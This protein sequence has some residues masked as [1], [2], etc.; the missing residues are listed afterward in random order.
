MGRVGGKDSF[1]QGRKDVE[2][3]AGIMVK[4]KAV[5]RVSEA[6]GEQV[7]RNSQRER[8]LA[9]SG[10]VVSFQPVPLLYIALDGTGVPVVPR[11]TEG[12]SGKDPTGKAKTRE[13]KL[14]CV[15]TQTKVDD[16]GHPVR[17]PASTT[18]VGAIETVEA[19]G[20]RIYAEAIRRGLTRA[21]KVILIGDGAPCDLGNRGRALSWSHPDCRPLSRAGALGQSRQNGAAK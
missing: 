16:E 2:E 6:L 8:E 18:Y 21:A 7:E 19:F 15:F 13:A 20:R 14:G 11:E 9:L 4:T 17:D 12:R 10:K 5:E 1:D 3:L